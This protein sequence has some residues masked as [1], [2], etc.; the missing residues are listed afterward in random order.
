MRKRSAERDFT[1]DMLPST[2]SGV[3][4]DRVKLHYATMLKIGLI[5]LAFLAPLFV[6]S[7]LCDLGKAA[8]FAEYDAGN[9]SYERTKALVNAADNMFGLI[10]VACCALSSIA[11]AGSA[12]V[13]KRLCWLE[14][15]FFGAEFRGGIK[16]NGAVYAAVFTAFGLLQFLCGRVAALSDS[17]VLTAIPAGV[18][19]TVFVPVMLFML[20]QACVYK[21][22]ITE[23]IRNS[24]A[25]YLKTAPKTLLAVLI[26][27][28]PTA[29]TL[30]P[31]II[32]K[33]ALLALTVVFILPLMA[34]GW[35][36]YGSSVLDN[37]INK[38]QF[39]ELYKRGLRNKEDKE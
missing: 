27:V 7:L 15:V 30:I 38:T 22:R 9:I 35:F 17:F 34:A 13:I 4:C 20:L 23:N 19:V 8:V 28:A 36:L 25:L 1:A 14:P 18:L 21:L 32:L 10:S 16:S 33:Y 12:N 2:R 6:C 3:F 24:I 26:A 39:P 31:N 5:M 29:L 11:A 37:A